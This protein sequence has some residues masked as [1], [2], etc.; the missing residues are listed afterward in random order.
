MIELALIKTKNYTMKGFI[1]TL[2]VSCF[3]MIMTA[4]SSNE[5]TELKQKGS[6]D[7][8][9]TDILNDDISLAYSL[10]LFEYLQWN[11]DANSWE[12]IYMCGFYN[13]V[14]GEI[15]FYKG[16]V[17]EPLVF[18]MNGITK[19]LNLLYQAYCHATGFNK[20]IYYGDPINRYVEN[21]KLQIGCWSITVIN[22]N[23]ELL[24]FDM[25]M[26]S[27]KDE[28]DWKA[29]AKYEI[30]QD[31]FRDFINSLR[32]E[33]QEEAYLA[34]VKMIRKE[35]GDRFDMNPYLEDMGIHRDSPSIVDLDE[36]ER[37]IRKTF[38]K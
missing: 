16:D 13:V 24:E 26:E 19:D 32:F 5:D 38:G 17:F 37:E 12:Q 28:P 2:A 25:T 10:D 8:F 34:I 1:Y 18:Y 15:I 4:C 9:L 21:P 29:H 33:S 20:K 27:Y 7:S 22:A 14:P 35:F 36:M 6:N 11:S 3:L 23:G 30:N 31:L